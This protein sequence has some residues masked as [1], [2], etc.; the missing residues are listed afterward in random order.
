[1]LDNFFNCFYYSFVW[2]ENM[3]SCR[4]ILFLLCT[5][6][7]QLIH[8]TTHGLVIKRCNFIKF[9]KCSSTAPCM[10]KISSIHIRDTINSNNFYSSDRKNEI[11]SSIHVCRRSDIEWRGGV[12]DRREY[13]A[14]NF[15]FLSARRH[16]RQR[17]QQSW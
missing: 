6:L 13:R 17:Q 16:E 5:E 8:S 12:S 7:T 14:L 3:G 11:I 9:S 15:P 2:H 1:M 10:S 4:Q